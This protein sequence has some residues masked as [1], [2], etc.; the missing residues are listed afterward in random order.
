M[1]SLLQKI[2]MVI[3]GEKPASLFSLATLLRGLSTGYG[4]LAQVKNAAFSRK[5]LPQKKLP[6]VVISI[7]NITVGGTGKTPMTLYI[8]NMVTS[9]GYSVVILSRGYKGRAEKAGGIVSNGN[10]L[11]MPPAEAG[12]EPYMMASTLKGVPVVVGRNRYE[13]GNL[14]IA[15]FS[16]DVILLDDGFQHIKLARDIDLVL[17]DHRRP[18]GNGYLLPRGPLREPVAAL[19]RASIIIET[20]CDDRKEPGAKLKKTMHRLSLHTPVFQSGHTPHIERVIPGKQPSL[21]NP[22]PS[23]H[24]YPL[25]L[26]RAKCVFAFSG[27]AE[28]LN[29][30]RTLTEIGCNLAGVKEF[31]DHYWYRESDLALIRMA[32]KEKRAE[33]ILTT[34]KDAVRIPKGVEWPRD[35]VVIGITPNLGN[36]TDALKNYIKSRLL[37]RNPG[38]LSHASP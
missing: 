9:L 15:A 37:M 35:L 36:Q 10:A 6:C 33:L 12:D 24:P 14:A 23:G 28:N 26:L 27:L 13:T 32:A 25:S 19:K 16:P 30:H 18:F 2:E 34:Q 38:V 31:P 11:L 21:P 29:F 7:G 1:R 8:A 3:N 4:I 5:I 22:D 17:V 20:R